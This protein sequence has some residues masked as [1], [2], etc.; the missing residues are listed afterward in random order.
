MRVALLG[1]GRMGREI[2]GILLERGHRVALRVA[3]P[4]PAR[5]EGTW[6]GVEVA[7]DFSVPEAVLP[8]VRRCVA[9]GV[10]LVVGTT[11][12]AERREKAEALAR[13]GGI[14]F[15]HAP[16]FSLGATL[17][18][19][20]AAEAARLLDGV[21]GY[22]AAVHEA[23]HRHK[24]DHPSGTA[25]RLAEVV[26]ARLGSKRGWTDRLPEGRAPDAGL[27]HVSVSR[28]GEIPGT[29]A[30]LIEGSDDRIEIRHEARSRAGFARGAVL[31]AEWIRG[32]R[33][34][35]TL[36]DLLEPTPERERS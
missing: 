29:H 17:F 20:I 32:R 14:G 12:W 22:D 5:E 26:V 36:E 16:N 27:L 3:G 28:A 2:E 33:G 19:R 6:E 23:H 30:L 21:E 4:A 13:E 9:E 15:L 35:F 11:G 25:R 7:I 1:Y 18:L 34:V 31:A 8:H 24:R 10:S